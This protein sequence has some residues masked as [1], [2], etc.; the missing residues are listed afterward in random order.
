MHM[1]SHEAMEIVF[2]PGVKKQ[3]QHLFCKQHP[4]MPSQPTA[5]RLS[6]SYK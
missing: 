3:R 1:A 2:P 6:K 5:I 4:A